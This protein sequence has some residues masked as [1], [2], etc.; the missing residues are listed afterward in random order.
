[1]HCDE[2]NE[3]TFS[4]RFQSF[5]IPSLPHTQ[6]TDEKYACM[7]ECRVR[8]GGEQRSSQGQSWAQG[9]RNA[10]AWAS[11][12]HEP[13]L[14]DTFIFSFF[15]LLRFSMKIIFCVNGGWE[16]VGWGVIW[17]WYVYVNKNAAV[18]CRWLC[19]VYTVN[20][21]YGLYEHLTSF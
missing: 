12:D 16:R 6:D 1:M 8:I 7:H 18:V 14:N 2:V 11:A 4:F 3:K 19:S 21:F 5:Y 17:T 15:R 20:G 9:A 13:H 10:S